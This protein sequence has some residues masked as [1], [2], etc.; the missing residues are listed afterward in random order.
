MKPYLTLLILTAVSVGT[1][2]AQIVADKDFI[3]IHSYPL[4]INGVVNHGDEVI[5]FKQRLGVPDYEAPPVWDD[6]RGNHLGEIWY[7]KCGFDVVDGRSYLFDFFD[8][9]LSVRLKGVDFRVG[10]LA[11]SL[12]EVFPQSWANR[13]QG[14]DLNQL[15]IWLGGVWD[16]ELRIGDDTILIEWDGT[17]RITR[18]RHF[19]PG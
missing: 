16:G 8:N 18:I 10:D 7:G 19:M 14:G 12:S 9:R 11:E 2:H 5:L 13:Y 6:Y 15:E 3:N 17:G 4:S 1:V